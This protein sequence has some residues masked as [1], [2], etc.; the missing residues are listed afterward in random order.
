ML[1]TIPSKNKNN[2]L[3]MKS[4]FNFYNF[5]IRLHNQNEFKIRG[6]YS[7]WFIRVKIGMPHNFHYK[8][9]GTIETLNNFF[10]SIKYIQISK[11][12]TQ[13][14]LHRMRLSYTKHN[15]ENVDL[16]VTT[17]QAISNM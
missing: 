17:C 13:K 1:L 5:I 6:Y 15:I 16:S 4:I 7:L 9:V 3:M 12:N 2:N 10:R 14:A 11:F 8:P